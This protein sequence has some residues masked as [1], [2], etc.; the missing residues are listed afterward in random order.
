MV[1]TVVQY[2]IGEFEE[3]VRASSSIMTRKELTGVVK[4]V[5]G[6]NRLLVKFQDGCENNL[7]YNQLTILI[8]ENIPEEKEPE[9][10]E[11]T[12]TPEEQV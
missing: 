7:S 12:E 8:V 1:G 5:S 3:E 11:I 4:G 2:K 10:F 9:V 6:K